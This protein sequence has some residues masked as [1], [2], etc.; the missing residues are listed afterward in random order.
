MKYCCSKWERVEEMRVK[1][2]TGI[3]SK[4]ALC[5]VPETGMARCWT[6]FGDRCFPILY[7]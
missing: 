6:F 1:K 3:K 2:W 4:Q 7:P 5:S